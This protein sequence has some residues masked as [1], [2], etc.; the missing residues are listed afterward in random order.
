MKAIDVKT[1]KVVD[2]AIPFAEYFERLDVTGRFVWKH[3]KYRRYVPPS[4]PQQHAREANTGSLT[5][6]SEAMAVHPT[7]VTE[8]RA[9]Y[10]KVHSGIT[11]KDD[12]SIAMNSRGARKALMKY[13]GYIDKDG[14]YGDA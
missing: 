4:E 6:K 9:L 2:V 11:V 3:R 13:N 1:D 14:G 8:A 7:Q 12:G 10:A 5:Y